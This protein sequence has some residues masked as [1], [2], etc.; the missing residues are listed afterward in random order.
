MNLTKL[1]TASLAIA[2][3]LT[4]STLGN[5]EKLER[6]TDNYTEVIEVADDAVVLF[7]GVIGTVAKLCVDNPPV[8]GWQRE[9]IAKPL[10]EMTY[11]VYTVASGAVDHLSDF[12]KRIVQPGIELIHTLASDNTLSNDERRAAL[13]NRVFEVLTGVLR[14]TEFLPRGIREFVELFVQG[15]FVQ[16]AL[17]TV[18]GFLGEVL[19]QVW[20]A[21]HPDLSSATVIPV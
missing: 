8:D 1:L 19:Y 6:L 18:A 17:K 10:A 2:A 5:P 15:Q 20:K 9:M 7:P 21:L 4:N 14:L 16:D 3:T 13:E 11:Q 12:A